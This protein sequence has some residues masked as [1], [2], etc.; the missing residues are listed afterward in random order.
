VARALEIELERLNTDD[1]YFK[2]LPTLMK[3]KRDYAMYTPPPF[4]VQPV[5]CLTMLSPTTNKQ[6]FCTICQ[7]SETLQKLTS[8]NFEQQ[9]G[10]K[11]KGK[12][13]EKNLLYSY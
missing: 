9:L 5:P 10:L 12:N 8:E 11:L 4:R 1:S 6:K 7:N 2:S 3:S 13:K